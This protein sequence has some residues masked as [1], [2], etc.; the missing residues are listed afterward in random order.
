MRVSNVKMLKGYLYADVEVGTGRFDVV[1]HKVRLNMGDPEV[2]EALGPLNDL[3]V[4]RSQAAH[5][6]LFTEKAVEQ[7]VRAAVRRQGPARLAR[8]ER[9][10]VAHLDQLVGGVGKTLERVTGHEVAK[11]DPDL[12][13][14]WAFGSRVARLRAIARQLEEH[15][16]ELENERNRII[17]QARNN[18]SKE[19]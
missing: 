18:E 16:S 15:S 19:L 7:E 5:L 3:L 17:E 4:Q 14:Q 2:V 6:A 9:Q 11:I 13:T 12:E 8:A 10:Q 1:V